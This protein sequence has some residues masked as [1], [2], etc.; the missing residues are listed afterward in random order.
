MDAF[1]DEEAMAIALKILRDVGADTIVNLGDFLDFAEFG[2]FEMEPAFAK[3][4]QA[5]I[6]Y[7]RN[8]TQIMDLCLA[9]LVLRQTLPLGNSNLFNSPYFL[10]LYPRTLQE[11]SNFP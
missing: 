5:G 8:A 11:V 2:K 9:F 1:H 3:T 6:D 7:Y 10:G 4:S